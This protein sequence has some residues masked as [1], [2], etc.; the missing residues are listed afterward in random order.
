M[1]DAHHRECNI[2]TLQSRIGHVMQADVPRTPLNITD[3]SAMNVRK[4]G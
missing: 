2:P 3:V 1:R 4:I